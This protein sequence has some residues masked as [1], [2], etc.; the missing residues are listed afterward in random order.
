MRGQLS[1][2]IRVTPTDAQLREA[3]ASTRLSVPF[4][5]AM[6]VP[7]LAMAIANVAEARLRRR[8]C[9]RRRRG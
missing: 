1:L 6:Q 3:H 2:G 8:A 5:R 7:A 9:P 4:E